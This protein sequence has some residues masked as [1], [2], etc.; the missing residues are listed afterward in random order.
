ME[1]S[2]EYPGSTMPAAL[3]SIINCPR[4]SVKV[5]LGSWSSNIWC[6]NF[7]WRQKIFNFQAP[8]T[9][10][11]IL[12]HRPRIHS[13]VEILENLECSRGSRGI[14]LARCRISRHFLFIHAD[15]NF[16]NYLGLAR[17]KLFPATSLRTGPWMKPT[18]SFSFDLEGDFS[19]Q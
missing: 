8:H 14:S 16:C 11:W 6:E 2:I 7:S 17:L 5:S 15:F 18:F 12:I 19:Q 4:T 1:F 3:D 10:F 9:L 13:W